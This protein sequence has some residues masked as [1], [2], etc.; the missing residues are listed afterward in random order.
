MKRI[1]PFLP[2]AAIALLGL[3]ADVSGY[4]DPELAKVLFGFAALF[5]VVPALYYTLPWLRRKVQPMV[6]VILLGAAIGAA[7][8]GLG[9]FVLWQTFL[10]PNEAT[11]VTAFQSSE[12]EFDPSKL[13]R[14]AG[15]TF[16]NEEVE[17]DGKFFINC[18]FSHVILI[19]RGTGPVHMDT[20][21]FELPITIKM[22]SRLP[23]VML[24]LLKEFADI[25]PQKLAI[26]AGYNNGWTWV[27]FN[28]M[29][30]K[31]DKKGSE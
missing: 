25:Q 12:E 29:P 9:S 1:I 3:A 30:I 22:P 18:T 31:E 4:Q 13:E 10:G 21:T 8:G 14:I 19:Y 24:L 28:P 5:L 6:W 15:K 27:E 17:I 20:N 26:S 11:E 16:N 2:G 23:H 7:I